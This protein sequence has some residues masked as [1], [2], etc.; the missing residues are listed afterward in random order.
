MCLMH[1]DKFYENRVAL[2]Y[3]D[4]GLYDISSISTDILRYQLIPHC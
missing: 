1:F 3:N 2:G 4:I